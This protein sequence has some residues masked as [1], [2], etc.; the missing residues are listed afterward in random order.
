MMWNFFLQSCQKMYCIIGVPYCDS[1]CP[2]HACYCKTKSFLL[3]KTSLVILYYWNERV[4]WIRYI[5]YLQRFP[6]LYMIMRFRIQVSEMIVIVVN[7]T[8]ASEYRFTALLTILHS[9][10]FLKVV[11]RPC[12][13]QFGAL[14]LVNSSDQTWAEVF[15]HLSE[16]VSYG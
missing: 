2:L 9:P 11:R 7:T 14:T 4:F 6:P 5:P 3:W 15:T 16:I 13:D 1:H 12:S 10:I 8:T